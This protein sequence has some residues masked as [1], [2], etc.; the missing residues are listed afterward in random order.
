VEGGGGGYLEEDQALGLGWELGRVAL[1]LVPAEEALTHR[2][3]LWAGR[4]ERRE[5][6]HGF[7]G[8][9]VIRYWEG[10]GGSLSCV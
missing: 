8:H 9:R 10:L 1:L 7:A 6:S 4:V 2:E 5:L 3:H